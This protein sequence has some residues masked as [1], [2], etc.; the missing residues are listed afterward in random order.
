MILDLWPSIVK[1]TTL[2]SIDGYPASTL[3]EYFEYGVRAPVFYG[4]LREQMV[5]NECLQEACSALTQ[6][7]P[8]V[9]GSLR[10][11]TGE[12]SLGILYSSSQYYKIIS[13]SAPDPT[14]N[15]H[16]QEGDLWHSDAPWSRSGCEIRSPSEL[17]EMYSRN[18]V[19]RF[20]LAPWS[21]SGCGWR[22]PGRN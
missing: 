21:R 16:A 12:H 5:F 13:K 8:K 2:A 6:T 9:S 1:M 15:R 11:F 17:R 18:P 20:P 7:Y 3:R 14:R 22:R 19:L 4:K 10:E